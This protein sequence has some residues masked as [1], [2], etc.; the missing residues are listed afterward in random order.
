MTA[1]VTMSCTPIASSFLDYG[2]RSQNYYLLSIALTC[3]LV[4]GWSRLDSRKVS[5]TRASPCVSKMQQEGPTRD[6]VH[7]ASGTRNP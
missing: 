6:K 7:L 2:H 3:A 4:A 1:F 5:S